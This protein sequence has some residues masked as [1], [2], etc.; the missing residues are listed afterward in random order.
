MQCVEECIAHKKG[1]P[2]RL[3]TKYSPIDQLPGGPEAKALRSDKVTADLM[4]DD[5]FAD[6][7]EF[8]A[9]ELSLYGRSQG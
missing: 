3:E 7:V 4:L 8:E 2:R 5:D 6:K 1:A 9:V